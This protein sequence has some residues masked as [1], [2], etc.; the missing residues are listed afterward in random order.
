VSVIAAGSVARRVLVVDDDPLVLRSM[1]RALTRNGFDVLTA[2]SVTEA[3]DLAADA[4]IDAAIVDYALTRE[5]GLVVLSQL[6]QLQPHCVRVL[7]TGRTELPV[8]VEAVNAG[9]VAKVIRK[10]FPMASMLAQ[11]E[12]ALDSAAQLERYTT[13]KAHA[14]S[15][16]ERRALTEAV[17]EGM[18]GMALQPIVSV[19]NGDVRPRFYEALLRPR[20]QQLSSPPSLLRAAEKQGR[21]Q[22]VAGVVLDHALASVRRVPQGQGLFVNL[23]PEQLGR[24]D[25]LEEHL[26]PYADI[27]QQITLEITERSRLQ[28][29]DRWE[30]SI[31]RVAALGFGI[32]VDDL[33][34]GYSSLSILADLRPQFI[35]LDM[36]LV[37][38]IHDKPRKQRLVELMATFGS[39]TQSAV[40]AEGV[41]EQAEADVLLDMGVPFLQGYLYGRPSEDTP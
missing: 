27:S 35:K 5:S 9:E 6:R 41:E 11:L 16:A 31:E 18:L 24:P 8:F 12:E 17:G 2:E 15:Q 36:S 26:E 21:V 19:C 33:G 28:S 30:E 3:L 10:P 25:L 1:Y 29:I 22:E 37:R 38:G 7:C 34:A 39:A 13:E 14:V 23:H 40:I 20:H 4:R 32:A